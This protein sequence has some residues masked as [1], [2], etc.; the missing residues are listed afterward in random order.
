MGLCIF[1]SLLHPSRAQLQHHRH[2]LGT[3]GQ[4]AQLL[5]C[6]AQRSQSWQI[7]RRFSWRASHHQVGAESKTGFFVKLYKYLDWLTCPSCAILFNLS[8]FFNLFI[9]LNLSTFLT[10]P[11]CSTC[12]SFS[13]CPPFSDSCNWTQSRRT[14]GWTSGSGNRQFHWTRKNCKSYW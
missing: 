9:L 13:T 12:P 14:F 4:R 6:S 11:S 1:F 5:N 10:C 3:F 8:I 7:C 2:R